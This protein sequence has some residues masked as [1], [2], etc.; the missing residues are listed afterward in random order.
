MAIFNSFLYVYKRVTYLI[1]VHP[2]DPKAVTL[3]FCDQEE[4]PGQGLDEHTTPW[5][6]KTSIPSGRQKHFANW[7]TMENP[8]FDRFLSTISM[9]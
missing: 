3:R 6:T 7:K 8:M 5:T 2:T 4:P 1:Y 9:V